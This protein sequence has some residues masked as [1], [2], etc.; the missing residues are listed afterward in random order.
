VQWLLVLASLAE[1]HL[2][3]VIVFDGCFLKQDKDC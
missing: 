1:L 2:L 3:A